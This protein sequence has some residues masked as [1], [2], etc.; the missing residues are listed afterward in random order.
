M[1]SINISLKFLL[2]FNRVFNEFPLVFHLKFILIFIG[3]QLVF[4][5]N[6]SWYLI[7]FPLVFHWKFYLISN[8]FQLVFYWNFNLISNGFPLVFYWI[9]KFPI[10]FYWHFIDI[11]IC[12][13]FKISTG[14]KI[15]PT[16]IT[17][18]LLFNSNWIPNGFPF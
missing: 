18:K 1:F 16:G 5:W 13:S 9:V 17:L 7:E 11:S 8:G 14:Y 4:L 2:N 3:F 6:L 12:I 10:N 15:D